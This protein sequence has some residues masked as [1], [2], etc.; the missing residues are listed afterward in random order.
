MDGNV[1][2]FEG[3]VK[4]TI[5]VEKRGEKGFGYD[6]VFCPEGSIF[7]FAEMD[8]ADK[9]KISHR[10]IAFKKLVSFLNNEK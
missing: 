7:T 5:M 10:G 9:N 6:P 2:F 3:M 4:G 1:I 8:L